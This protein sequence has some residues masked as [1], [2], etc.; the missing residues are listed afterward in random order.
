MVNI[1][2]MVS[3]LKHMDENIKGYAFKGNLQRDIN[4]AVGENTYS[5]DEIRKNT[6]ALVRTGLIEEGRGNAFYIKRT[7]AGNRMLQALLQTGDCQVM[8]RY[9]DAKKDLLKNLY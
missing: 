3:I 8:A 2:C 9:V 4:N 6:N 7:E 5:D 1:E